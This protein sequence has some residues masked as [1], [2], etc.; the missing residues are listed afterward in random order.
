VTPTSPLV[1]SP[2]PWFIQSPTPPL[3]LSLTPPLVLSLTPPL[4]LSLSKGERVPLMDP[5]SSP[6][7]GAGRQHHDL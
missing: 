5:T 2:M 1:L 7:A 6:W 4:V 3:G